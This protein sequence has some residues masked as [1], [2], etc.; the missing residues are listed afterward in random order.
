MLKLV[1]GVTN[2]AK[3]KKRKKVKSKD[4]LLFSS[5]VVEW[6]YI[7]QFS[8]TC[9][10]LLVA[11]WVSGSFLTLKIVGCQSDYGS[12]ISRC[13]LGLAGQPKPWGLE[14]SLLEWTLPFLIPFRLGLAWGLWVLPWT[15][16]TNIIIINGKIKF[17]FL[18]NDFVVPLQKKYK[19]K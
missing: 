5:G 11:T 7:S 14:I 1:L 13:T 2:L 19:I 12:V 8:N 18:I 9:P 4:Y 3:L 10:W 6:D 17:F 15:P 16:S